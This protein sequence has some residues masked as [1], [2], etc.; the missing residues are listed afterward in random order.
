MRNSAIDAEKLY[1]LKFQPLYMERIWGG[2]LM[3]EHLGRSLPPHNDP[4][5]ES[6]E[7]V[8]REDAASIVAEGE[9]AGW[10]LHELFQH[11]GSAF[12][13]ESAMRYERFPIL[14]KL[15]DAG[16]KLSLQVHPEELACA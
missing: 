7:L 14:V 13:G 9:L 3:S 2:T 8:D 6:W 4:I 16:E 15:I 10:S 5:G 1:P 12:A 11:Y